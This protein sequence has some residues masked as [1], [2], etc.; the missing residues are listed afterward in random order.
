MSITFTQE[1]LVWVSFFVVLL[2]H[3]GIAGVCRLCKNRNDAV[4]AGAVM[5]AIVTL[6]YAA[7]Y[8]IWFPQGIAS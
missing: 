1:F 5:H 3:A 4:Y 7:F 6:L 8:P 2:I